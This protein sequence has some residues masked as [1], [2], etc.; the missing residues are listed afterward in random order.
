M[1]KVLPN[2][3]YSTLAPSI[4]VPASL[5]RQYIC[6]KVTLETTFKIARF[7]R[8]VAVKVLY[9]LLQKSMLWC[10]WVWASETRALC[11]CLLWSSYW[12]K[13]T[14]IFAGKE[15]EENWLI[16]NKY[17]TWMTLSIPMQANSILYRN[18]SSLYIQIISNFTKQTK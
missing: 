5:H 7:W 14:I 15:R 10:K 4:K 8:K 6:N 12:F 17:L 13:L 9:L 11:S 18:S 1:R 3:R 16:K 2:F